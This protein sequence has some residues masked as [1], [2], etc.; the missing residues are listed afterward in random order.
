M[1]VER[2]DTLTWSD[3]EDMCC[4]VCTEGFDY[5]EINFFP[6][7]CGFQICKFCW[8]RIANSDTPLCPACRKPY[9]NEPYLADGIS[10]QLK[11]KLEAAKKDAANK[12]KNPPT[13]NNNN[14][15]CCPDPSDRDL[16]NNKNWNMNNEK[17]VCESKKHLANVRVLQK[18]LVFVMGLS[19]SM[20]NEE[21]LK[22]Y[23]HFGRYGP[24]KKVVISTHNTNYAGSK[25]TATAA[26][27]LTYANHDDALKA[28][29]GSNGSYVSSRTLKC[30]LGTT[31]YCS[32]YL[33]RFCVWKICQITLVESMVVK[34]TNFQNL[35]LIWKT[36]NARWQIACI[37]TM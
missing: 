10:D 30:S 21:T 20:A 14:H 22:K 29:Q 5:D 27:Y 19:H 18:N 7:E 16:K 36:R 23:E 15:A 31:K 13:D 32:R 4:A 35:L 3:F 9:E 28:I 26:A 37:Y 2:Y 6:C 25:D 33:E 1:P 11:E 8:D 17:S 24:I 34:E 12:S